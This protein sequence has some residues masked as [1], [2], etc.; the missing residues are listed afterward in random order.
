MNVST[1]QGHPLFV[2]QSI[3]QI[4]QVTY[5]RYNAEKRQARKSIGSE[6]LIF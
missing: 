3:N 6:S 2:M 4:G 1:M 5:C